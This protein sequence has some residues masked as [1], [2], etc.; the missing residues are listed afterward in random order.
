[1]RIFF[2][3]SIFWFMGWNIHYFL[4]FIVVGAC[5]CCWCLC[6]LMFLCLD[7]LSTI[8]FSF[9]LITSSFLITNYHLFPNLS[10]PFKLQYPSTLYP[11]TIYHPYSLYFIQYT[12]SNRDMPPLPN[13]VT[14]K[15]KQIQK[16]NQKQYTVVVRIQWHNHYKRWNY[17]H[18]KH[19]SMANFIPLSMEWI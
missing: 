1:M 19:E 5:S 17:L 16:Q 14:T 2:R 15:T 11:I 18:L 8:S 6:F 12:L 4:D 9:Q 10:I 7:L 3:L 13:L